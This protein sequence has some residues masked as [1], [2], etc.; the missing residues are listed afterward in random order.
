VETG[1]PVRTEV[2][3]FYHLKDEKVSEFWLLADS[4]FDCKA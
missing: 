1:D 2:N 4:D 3:Y